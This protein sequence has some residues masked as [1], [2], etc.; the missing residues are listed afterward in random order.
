MTADLAILCG[1]GALPLRLSQAFPDALCITFDGITHSLAAS[2]AHSFECLGHLFEALK[3]NNIRRVVMAGS[4]QRPALNPSKFDDV[5][6]GIA[7]YLVAALQKGDDGLFR[8]VIELFESRGFQVCGAHELVPELTAIAGQL[9]DHAPEPQHLVDIDK[10]FAM[11][12][13]LSV[14]DIGQSTVFEHGLCLGVETLQGT[15]AL[16]DFVARTPIALRHETRGVLIKTPKTGQDLRVDMPT[17]GPSTIFLV[18]EAGLA[19]I[20]ISA[21]QVLVL[22]PEKTNALIA[23]YGLFL[24]ARAS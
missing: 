6:Q 1:A 2:E 12:N 16:L 24:F 9:S 14:A 22:E 13:F 21:G 17:I 3:H 23:Q 4:M 5:M 19:G 7:P 11:L 18:H 15:D 10:G 20:A 8:F